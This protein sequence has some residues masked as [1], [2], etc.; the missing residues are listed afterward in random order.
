M[1][2]IEVARTLERGGLGERGAE[3]RAA[4]LLKVDKLDTLNGGDKRDRVA[5]PIPDPLRV[6]RA[7]SHRWTQVI[8]RA[9]L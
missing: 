6:E 7:T 8:T 2:S 9:P 1:I 4:E 3:V 5:E